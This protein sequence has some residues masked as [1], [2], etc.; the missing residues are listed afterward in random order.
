MNIVIYINMKWSFL[1]LTL[2]SGFAAQ[3]QLPDE[4][5]SDRQI[6]VQLETVNVVSQRNWENDTVRYRYNQM[7]HYVISILP[8]LDEAVKLFSEIDEY[9]NTEELDRRSRKEFVREKEELVRTRFED[10]IRDLNTTQGVLLVKL[11]ARQTGLNIYE[12]LSEFKNPITAMK[13]Q[14]WAKINGFNINRRYH[15]LDEPDLEQIMDGLGY[16]LPVF[17]ARQD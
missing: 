5:E 11:I 8:Y 16:P 6:L 2:F 1:L 17:Y 9:L 13:W 3:A 14:T 10:Q 7:R 12:I 15:P 4:R